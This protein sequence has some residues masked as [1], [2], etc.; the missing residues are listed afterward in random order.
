MSAG[1]AGFIKIIYGHMLSIRTRSLRTAISSLPSPP[2]STPPAP[3]LVLGPFPGTFFNQQITGWR[4][5]ALPGH[6]YELGLGWVGRRVCTHVCA[7][8]RV[9]VCVC[10]C[11]HACVSSLLF[12]KTSPDVLNSDFH[13]FPG[14]VSLRSP[15]QYLGKWCRTASMLPK[16]RRG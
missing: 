5:L 11:A 8:M 4:A 10:V 1:C 14:W 3:L 7:H 6:A 12:L 9:C 2:A 13:S 16:T 15:S